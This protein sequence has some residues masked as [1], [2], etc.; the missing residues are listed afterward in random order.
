M[1]PNP[2]QNEAER[3]ACIREFLRLP[4]GYPGS[5]PTSG[6]GFYLDGETLYTKPKPKNPA[7][8][9]IGEWSQG[10]VRIHNSRSS[11]GKDTLK[12][13]RE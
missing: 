8:A 1:A 13:A 7:K 9:I 12:A 5:V 4:T 10:R 11:L 2:P 3:Q 6:K